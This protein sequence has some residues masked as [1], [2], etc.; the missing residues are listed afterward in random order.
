MEC[1]AVIGNLPNPH[2]IKLCIVGSVCKWVSQIENQ[3][4]SNHACPT[5]TGQ[6]KE[7]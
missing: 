7:L 1:N 6:P 3:V 5:Y 4:E 2:V